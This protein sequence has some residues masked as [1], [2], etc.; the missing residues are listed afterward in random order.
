MGRTVHGIREWEEMGMPR[1]VGCGR[2]GALAALSVVLVLTACGA[3]PTTPPASLRPAA[4]HSPSIPPSGQQTPTAPT[5]VP[6]PQPPTVGIRDVDLGGLTVTADY[7]GPQVI[8]LSG[9]VGTFEDGGRAEL[10]ASSIRYGDIDG[11]GL[12][13]ALAVIRLTLGN[14]VLDSHL[15]WRWDPD[16]A[17]PAQVKPVLTSNVRCGDVIRSMTPNGDGTVTMQVAER[18]PSDA[19]VCA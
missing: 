15:V 4:S 10:D 8:A 5:A 12:P 6:P 14:G 11:D 3:A 7:F 19:G 13:D 17:A 16:A 2:R 1:G 18:D 9:G